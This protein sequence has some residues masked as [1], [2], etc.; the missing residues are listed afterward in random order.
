MIDHSKNTQHKSLKIF[1]RIFVILFWGGFVLLCFLNRDKLSVDGI[2]ELVPKN[3]ILSVVVMLLLYAVKSIAVFIYG[4]VLYAASGILFSLP[5]AIIVNTIGT[6]IMTTIPFYIGKR[7][8]GHLIDELVKKNSKLEL[9]RDMQNKNQFFVSFFLRMVG[10]L[11]ADLVAM[12]LGAS[13]MRYKPYLFGT[14]VGLMPSIVCF[15]VMGMSIDDVGS[16]QFIISLIVEAGLML[17]S[18][19]IYFIWKQ[20]NK[21][22][23]EMTKDDKAKNESLGD[24]E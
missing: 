16:P 19:L 7:A 8:G 13:G 1:G 4:G 14:V 5:V 23:R 3:S 12:Y 22:K 15:S 18:I 20:Q 10:L 6:I 21:K 24:V 11:P 2:V 17:L 9:L